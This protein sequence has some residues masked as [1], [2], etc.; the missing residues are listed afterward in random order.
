METNNKIHT[1]GDNNIEL[2]NITAR[3]IN[4]ITG[5]EDNSEVKAKK[6]S[7][8]TNIVELIKQLN[9]KSKE[10]EAFTSSASIDDFDDVEFDDLIDAIKFDNC[11]LFVGPEI[12]VNNDGKNIHEEFY[13]S[14]NSKKI[15]YDSKEGFFSP[16]SETKLINKMKRFYSETF[17]TENQAGYDLLEKLAQIPFNLIVSASPDD[18]MHRIFDTHNKKH[19]FVYYN[20]DEQV[21]DE[22][23]KDNPVVF[24]FL[25]N[26][27]NNGKFIFTFEQFHDYINKKRVIK[28]PVNIEAKVAEAVHYLFIGFNFEKWYNRL[29]LLSFKLNEDVESYTFSDSKISE[30]TKEFIEE[31]FNI[32]YIDNDYNDFVDVLLG[33]T[34]EAGLTYSLNEIFISNTLNALDRIRV[35]AIDINKLGELIEIENEM[36]QIKDKF[37]K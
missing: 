4:I 9:D 30:E 17:H 28:I 33:K 11:I 23:N 31:Q 14:I 12:A 36:N 32:S 29:A 20:E 24:N 35:K 10:N 6:E 8:A 13:D 21:V 16:D 26:P 7:I 34:H 15:K 2:Q 22:P 37:F 3:D 19:S 5:K 1:F 25:G 27:S 18:T